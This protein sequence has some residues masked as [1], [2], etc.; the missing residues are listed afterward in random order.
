MAVRTV[1]SGMPVLTVGILQTK[2]VSLSKGH[3]GVTIP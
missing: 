3:L 1:N 2:G